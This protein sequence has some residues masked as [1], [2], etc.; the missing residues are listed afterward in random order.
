MKIKR[1]REMLEQTTPDGLPVVPRDYH[2]VVHTI[3]DNGGVFEYHPD[4]I[5]SWR[6]DYSKPTLAGVGEPTTVKQFIEMLREAHGKKVIGYKGGDYILDEED[7]LWADDYGE[8]D[9]WAIVAVRLVAEAKHIE[10]IRVQ[11]PETW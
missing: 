8:A 2:V 11:V 4:R 9:M 5:T 7:H 6:G 1:I 10:L 3:L